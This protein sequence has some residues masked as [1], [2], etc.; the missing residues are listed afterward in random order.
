MCCHR[1]G[2]NEGLADGGDLMGK[3][4]HLKRSSVQQKPDPHL[5]GARHS[6]LAEGRVHNEQR[7][8]YKGPAQEENGFL[9]GRANE[10]ERRFTFLSDFIESFLLHFI[11][12]IVYRVCQR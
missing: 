7:S 5:T 8:C 12:Y 6:G 10:Q 11:K 1:Q 2:Y 9:R 4:R 3:L